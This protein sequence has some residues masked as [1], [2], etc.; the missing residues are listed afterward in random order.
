MLWRI[1]KRGTDKGGGRRGGERDA[2][3]AVRILV[4]SF[5]SNTHND[6]AALVTNDNT[7]YVLVVI[8]Y[9]FPVKRCKTRACNNAALF[10]N[11]RSP[12]ENYFPQAVNFE[13]V[14]LPQHHHQ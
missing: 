12:R 10:A 6:S 14:L 1:Q 7:L 3:K 13:L 11:V 8:M 9:S 4:E 2:D 5:N